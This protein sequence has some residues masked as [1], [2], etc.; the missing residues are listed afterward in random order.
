MERTPVP[1]A[2]PALVDLAATALTRDFDLVRIR[3][4]DDGRFPPSP[5]GW[6]L[7]LQ[8][9]QPFSIYHHDVGPRDG[10]EGPMISQ[11]NVHVAADGT[12][13]VDANSELFLADGETPEGE[14]GDGDPEMSLRQIE[15]WV[16]TQD[17]GITD[18]EEDALHGD[19]RL[20]VNGV[21]NGWGFSR[22]VRRR[23]AELNNEQAEA[24]W[25]L[26]RFVP[27]CTVEFTARNWNCDVP[28]HPD[29]R[30]NPGSSPNQDLAAIRPD[31]YDASDWY[32]YLLNGK[33]ITADEFGE[34]TG[35]LAPW[36]DTCP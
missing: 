7:S 25:D 3:P 2:A 36:A 30:N 15:N 18:T 9:R 14:N 31:A 29:N 12:A 32:T 6:E 24:G 5:D 23:E 35:T 11:I 10:W 1:T 33:N 28:G 19:S 20:M 21:A 17:S 4:V 13:A 34:T 27:G 26:P 16:N 22:V 8:F